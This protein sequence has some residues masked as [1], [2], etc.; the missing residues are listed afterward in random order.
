MAASLAVRL[1]EEVDVFA[2]I[3]L[4]VATEVTSTAEFSVDVPFFWGGNRDPVAFD[5]NSCVR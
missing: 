1:P 4:G 3:G 5:S 2:G